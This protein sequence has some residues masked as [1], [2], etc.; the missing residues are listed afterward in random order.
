MTTMTPDSYLTTHRPDLWF[1]AVGLATRLTGALYVPKVPL[2]DGTIQ[3][4]GYRQP[5]PP[6]HG[7][8]T[9]HIIREFPDLHER[10]RSLR[11]RLERER[12][13]GDTPCGRGEWER[14]IRDTEEKIRHQ[15]TPPPASDIEPDTERDP[16]RGGLSTAP[17]VIPVPDGAM[18]WL[19]HE[20]GHW[21]A[22]TEEERLLPD[23]GI[24][25][26]IAGVDGGF[27]RIVLPQNDSYRAAREWQAWAWEEIVLAPWGPA[28]SFVPPT[29]AGGVAFA[30][31]GPLEDR[32]LRHA[33]RQAGE[34]RVDVEEWR[35]I[36]GEWVRW[37][38]SQP[39]P[40]WLRV[41]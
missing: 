30:R 1:R 7:P 38:R 31:P 15:S 33:A 16:P 23:Y 22:A 40:S 21:V 19:L 12:S 32:H 17:I 6:H 26:E 9:W 39:V 36:Y 25:D 28:R 35:A 13:I 27:Q 3:A 4:C 18:E 8:S 34:L 41:N 29:Q 24:A 10:L 5:S 2:P 37:E 11:E 20:V 14:A